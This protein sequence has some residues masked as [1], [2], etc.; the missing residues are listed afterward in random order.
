LVGYIP[1]T[2]TPHEMVLSPDGSTLYVTNYDGSQIQ[3]IKVSAL[4]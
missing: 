2:Q 3:I 1:A 4:P